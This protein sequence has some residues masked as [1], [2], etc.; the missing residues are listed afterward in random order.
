ME[1]ESFLS[2]LPSNLIK[3]IK[4]ENWKYSHSQ[5]NFCQGYGG[6]SFD[7]KLYPDFIVPT[8]YSWSEKFLKAE[9][10]ICLNCGHFQRYS[11]LTMDELREYLTIYEDKSKTHQNIVSKDNKAA[12]DIKNISRAK[13]IENCCKNIDIKPKKIFIARPTSKHTIN[14]VRDLYPFSKIEFHENDK[15]VNSQ[16]KITDPNILSVKANVHGQLKISG[17]YDIYIIIHCLQHSI[18]FNDDLNDLISRTKKGSYIILI[19]EIQRKLHNPF[20]VNHLSEQFLI[21]HLKCK[22]VSTK[23]VESKENIA[24]PMV[25]GLQSSD[26]ETGILLSG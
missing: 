26:W 20:H 19:E 16:I 14:K 12:I 17:S 4:F 11:K 2:Q 22:G 8:G 3:G 5:C 25:R 13:L 24:N 6:I 15:N 1:K 21:S 9:D 10:G 7:H 23:I 18:N